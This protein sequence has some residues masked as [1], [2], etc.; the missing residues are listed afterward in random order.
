MNVNKINFSKIGWKFDNTYT[1]LPKILLSITKPDLAPKPEISIFNYDLA[2]KLGLDFS[3]LE[4]DEIANIFS[5][6][7]LPKDSQPISQAYGGHQFGFFSILGDGRAIILGEH[8]DPNNE[9]YDIQF[10]G[11]GKT[12]YSRGGDGKATLGSMLREYLISEAMHNLKI[13][14]TR[15]LA[16]IKT[17]ENILRENYLEGSIL[18]RIAK[19]HI[20]VGTF[21]LLSSKNDK[22]SLNKLVNYTINRHFK[23]YENNKI[24][25][26]NNKIPAIKL[27]RAVIEKQIFLIRKARIM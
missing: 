6:N 14:S 11:S 8:I 24:P 7:T 27:L 21:Q 26:I 20:R 12:P 5:G 9:R 13:P 2:N 19:S 4:K 23:K 1:N 18:T 15:S 10:K 17:G 3:N 22:T 25:A 16:V